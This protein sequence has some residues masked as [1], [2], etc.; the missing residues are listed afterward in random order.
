MRK[1]I[2]IDMDCF[3]AAVEERDNP[4]LLG[5]AMA[6]GGQGDRRGVLCTANY[7][8]RNYGVR[9]AMS[10]GRALRL[11]PHLIVVPVRMTEYKEA[12]AKVFEIFRRYTDTI[13][14]ISLDEAFLDVT[15][16][17]HCH[18]SATLIA[19]EIRQSIQTELGLTAS[20]GIAENKFLAKIASDLNK[21]NGQFI[22]LP[23]EVPDFMKDL[24]VS[25]IWGVG[26]VTAKKMKD[27]GVQTCAD[28]QNWSIKDLSRVFGRFGQELYNYSRGIDE[29][30][31]KVDRSRKSFSQERTFAEDL[32]P[33]NCAET[34]STLHEYFAEKLALYLE[35][36]K[37]FRIKGFFVKVKFAD[38]KSTTVDRLGEAPHL[39]D[40]LELLKEALSRKPM[41]VRL[42]GCGVRFAEKG[43]ACEEVLLFK[44]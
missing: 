28:L 36:H 33:N 15:D 43:E 4:E 37:D 17:K 35:K 24:S 25:K 8:A 12:S 44:D 34:L 10:T 27:L 9:S 2:H 40:Y 29:R 21:P 26:K 39:D 18:G 7:E 6:V 16:S 31:V 22:V 11:C 3:F 19:Q 38:F 42:L 14:A 23:E 5:K 20:A 41:R 30:P 32:T 13:Q 1:I